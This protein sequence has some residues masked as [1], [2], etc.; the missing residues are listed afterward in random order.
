MELFFHEFPLRN[1]FLT[2]CVSVSVIYLASFSLGFQNTV[3]TSPEIGRGN[4][5]DKKGLG[6][7]FCTAHACYCC[8]NFYFLQGKMASREELTSSLRTRN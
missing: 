5:K 1:M 6:T 7:K 3:S 4:L 2:Y 8:S